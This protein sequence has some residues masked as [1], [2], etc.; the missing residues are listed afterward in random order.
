MD[1]Y[2]ER[3]GRAADLSLPE[4]PRRGAGRRAHHQDHEAD[5]I[6]LWLLADRGYPLGVVTLPEDVVGD[7]DDLVARAQAANPAVSLDRVVQAIWTLGRRG[8]DDNLRQGIPVRTVL[9]STHLYHPCGFAGHRWVGQER[10]C[11]C[12]GTHSANCRDARRQEER[13]HLQAKGK[14]MTDVHLCWRGAAVGAV[15]V[16]GGHI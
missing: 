9:G 8:V 14:V 5:P 16:T 6:K 12:P 11:Q 3:G 2:R 4:P 10:K 15:S 13:C 7:V 1:A